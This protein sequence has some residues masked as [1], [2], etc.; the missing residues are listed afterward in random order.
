MSVI[1]LKAAKPTSSWA[2]NM[3]QI[4]SEE[5]Q[6]IA[7]TLSITGR[8]M[9]QFGRFL[10]DNPFRYKW[11]LEDKFVVKIHKS[12][13]RTI[14]YAPRVTTAEIIPALSSPA[15]VEI[16]FDELRKVAQ[17]GLDRIFKFFPY[18]DRRCCVFAWSCGC[19]LD[20]A[21]TAARGLSCSKFYGVAAAGKPLLPFQR[22]TEKS[23]S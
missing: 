13:S 6:L 20:F 18:Q 23:R 19:A 4:L 3:T 21:Q 16:G 9:K 22:K 5:P 12:W 11:Q 1:D 15:S 17:H 8:M 10:I 2:A 14:Q 7:S